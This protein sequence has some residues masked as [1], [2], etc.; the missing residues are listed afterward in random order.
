MLGLTSLSEEGGLKKL[1][2]VLALGNFCGGEGEK[3]W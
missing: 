2:D 3:R 1:L